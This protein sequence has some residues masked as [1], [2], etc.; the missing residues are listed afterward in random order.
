MFSKSMHTYNVVRIYH[1]TAPRGWTS[2]VVSSSMSKQLMFFQLA[3]I[4][5]GTKNIFDSHNSFKW[6]CI[7]KHKY[8]SLRIYF[9]KHQNVFSINIYCF[10]LYIFKQIIL[11]YIFL[12]DLFTSVYILEINTCF[13]LIRMYLFQSGILFSISWNLL[14][15]IFHKDSQYILY[16]IKIFLISK[17]MFSTEYWQ[18]WHPIALNDLKKESIL[19]EPFIPI[20][21][22]T[23]GSSWVFS[24]SEY[25]KN[26]SKC[27]CINE[28]RSRWS[29]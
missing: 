22:L 8:F 26:E 19:T 12:S 11:L 21:K 29:I 27:S 13:F 28:K 9:W 3:Y 14:G 1:I 25:H 16:R 15:K 5:A 23:L 17:K 18:F 10:K 20:V 7:F 4:F 2:N 24:E 6:R